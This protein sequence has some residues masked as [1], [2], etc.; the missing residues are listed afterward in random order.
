MPNFLDMWKYV[1]FLSLIMIFKIIYFIFILEFEYMPYVLR[2]PKQ[3]EDGIKVL[4]WSYRC[5]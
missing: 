4:S 2:C 1:I 3:P 5:L